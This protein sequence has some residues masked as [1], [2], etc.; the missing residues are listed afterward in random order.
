L[1]RVTEIRQEIRDA[2]NLRDELAIAQMLMGRALE[3]LSKVVDSNNP[4]LD[5]TLKHKLEL[6]ATDYV[7]HAMDKVRQMAESARK[8]EDETANLS[9][10]QPIVMQLLSLLDS[11]LQ[12]NQNKFDMVGVDPAVIMANINQRIQTDLMIPS[13]LGTTLTA[14]QLDAEVREMLDSV[15]DASLK[16]L[17]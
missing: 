12:H 15:P 7:Y 16:R 5:A 13:K 14:D 10:V 3:Y 11:E 9:L 2:I 17:G 1:T 4:S 6:Q 8:V